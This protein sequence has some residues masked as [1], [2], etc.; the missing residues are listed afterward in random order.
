[1]SHGENENFKSEWV[2]TILTERWN[3]IGMA[4]SHVVVFVST[5][6]VGRFHDIK[7]HVHGGTF[8]V[9]AILEY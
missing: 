9:E 7:L 3:P 2:E 1:M 4:L 5:A 6:F 8:S